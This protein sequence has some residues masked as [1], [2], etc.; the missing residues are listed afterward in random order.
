[1]ILSFQQ[2]LILFLSFF[3]APV[4]ALHDRKHIIFMVINKNGGSKTAILFHDN[5]KKF[6]KNRWIFCFCG[7]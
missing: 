2:L 7:C 3:F 5:K 6:N 1:M 4:N